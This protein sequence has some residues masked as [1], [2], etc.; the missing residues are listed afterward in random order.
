[1]KKAIR[2]CF[3]AQLN[4]HLH[5]CMWSHHLLKQ[6]KIVQRTFDNGANATCKSEQFDKVRVNSYNNTKG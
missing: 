5:V 6:F 1:M 3:I 2:I 4:K